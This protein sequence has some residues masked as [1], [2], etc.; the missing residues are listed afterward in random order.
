MPSE[1]TSSNTVG[2]RPWRATGPRW[3]TAVLA[4]WCSVS[5]AQ[6]QELPY[7][8]DSPPRL[9][10]P[11]QETVE[12]LAP[13]GPAPQRPAQPSL[14]QAL[15]TR[16]DLMLQGGT[17]KAALFTIGEQWR[18]NI[19]A[20]DVSGAVNGTFKDAK[21][22]EILDSILLSNG[23]GYRAVG[24]SLVV[25]QLSELGQVNPFFISETIPIAAADVNEVV[26]GAS[27][28]STPNGQV[29]AIPSA[30]S[31]VVLDF[32]DRVE[33]IKKFIAA[34]DAATVS[35]YQ[36]AP[37][38][39][40]GRQLEVAYVKTHHV[41]AEDMEALLQA[42]LSAE[43]KTTV[44]KKEDRLLVVDYPEN[45][46]MVQS[47]IARA[48]R[49]RPQVA[50][51]ALIYDISLQ[52][53]EE[54][55]LNWH[56]ASNGNF[57]GNTLSA[58]GALSGSGA[59]NSGTGTYFNSITKVPF[60]DGAAGGAFTLYNLSN[61]FS[62]AAVAMAL[63]NAADSRLLASPNV[64][65]TE[66]EEATI[67]SIQEIP[68][69]QLTQT[70]AGGNIGTTAFK[71]A[72]ITLTVIPKIGTD[73]TIEMQVK[74]EF[75][76]LTGFTPGDNQPIIDKRTA[77]TIVR[78]QNG[79]T[80]VIGGMR[81]RTDVGDFKGIPFLK[82]VRLIGPLFRSRET[83]VRESELLV[84]IRPTITGYCDPLCGREQRAADTIDCR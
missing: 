18:I 68:Y 76:R 52:D 56:S 80:L 79:H 69:Q 45:L 71:N 9:G 28:L 21:L 4:L 53:L 24:E 50:I 11:P 74:P 6:V 14:Q 49:P 48:D 22:R 51:Q 3:L 61:N 16:G 84:F 82:D 63:Q 34:V 81:Q 2:T 44:L 58:G 78:I 59:L 55:G 25:T 36:A 60:A 67:Q 66:N 5:A 30:R 77:T 7:P 65:V 1:S 62:M 19:V 46:R 42:V 10:G 70:A 47:V 38:V 15:E 54:I 64:T 8:P 73:H 35:A 72:G 31:V 39:A 26:Q 75:S 27:L 29:R 23:Y 40:T 12:P 37:Q 17:L 13:R 43:G 83:D 33:K 20:G 57:G 32:P 41:K